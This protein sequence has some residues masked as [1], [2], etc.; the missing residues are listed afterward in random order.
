[1]NLPDISI[2]CSAYPY[3]GGTVVKM[4]W[5]FN[6]V[7]KAGFILHDLF[8]EIAG[9]GVVLYRLLHRFNGAT[10][11]LCPIPGDV[12]DAEWLAAIHVRHHITNTDKTF[13]T[14]RLKLLYEQVAG[15]DK[16]KP[17]GF[18]SY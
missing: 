18:T 15:G 10:A 13:I 1:M 6:A 5:V 3:V 17:G 14:H 2:A 16:K 11:A 4:V 9:S 12:N 7:G 8:V